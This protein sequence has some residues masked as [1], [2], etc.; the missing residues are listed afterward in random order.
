MIVRA[1]AKSHLGAHDSWLAQSRDFNF[2]ARHPGSRNP[3]KFEPSGLRKPSNPKP[4]MRRS[5]RIKRNLTKRR[6][7]SGRSDKGLTRVADMHRKWRSTSRSPPQWLQRARSCIETSEPPSAVDI[8]LSSTFRSL[9]V[10]A[11]PSRSRVA[12]RLTT[13]GTRRRS[14][15][16]ARKAAGRRL[17]A[18]RSGPRS[19][20]SQ[21]A[22]PRLNPRSRRISSRPLPTKFKLGK[23][24]A[25][26]KRHERARP[27]LASQN[28]RLIHQPMSSKAR[29]CI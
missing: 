21:S 22:S 10:E 15:R 6:G 26:R 18:L 17:T 19:R 27:S 16:P 13:S 8:V 1:L 12:G 4:R 24:A 20:R 3:A 28:P 11:K 9:S 29:R 14:L 23:P 25:S 5:H 7:L 2:S